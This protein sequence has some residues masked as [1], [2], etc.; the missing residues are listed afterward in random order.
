[1]GKK[2]AGGSKM[3]RESEEGGGKG[4]KGGTLSKKVCGFPVP[5]LG[6]I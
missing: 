1:M 4:G 5:R 3:R 6:I 2:E